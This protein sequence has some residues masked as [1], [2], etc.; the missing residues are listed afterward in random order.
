MSRART[1]QHIHFS[2]LQ[3]AA[4]DFQRFTTERRGIGR[5][6]IANGKDAFLFLI[7]KGLVSTQS[8]PIDGNGKAYQ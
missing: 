4:I 8:L 3:I 1:V 5:A 7:Q 2:D 6:K